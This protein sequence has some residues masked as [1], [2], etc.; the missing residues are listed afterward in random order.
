MRIDITADYN[1]PRFILREAAKRIFDDTSYLFEPAL[2]EA[3]HQLVLFHESQGRGRW[4]K[5]KRA[6]IE[7]RTRAG[8]RSGTPIGVQTGRLRAS[9]VYGHPDHKVVRLNPQNWYS[10]PAPRVRHGTKDAGLAFVFNASRRLWPP[11]RG[12]MT[13]EV[14]RVAAEVFAQ[15]VQEVTQ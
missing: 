11:T 12:Q 2:K 6:T 8:Q 9:L 1:G 3:S 14:N 10:Y 4:R 5:L 15:K 13:E 7:R